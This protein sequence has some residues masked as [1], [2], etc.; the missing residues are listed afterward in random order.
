MEFFSETRV[1]ERAGWDEYLT[2]PNQ[3][4]N[5]NRIVGA[6]MKIS[7]TSVLTIA[8]VMATLAGLALGQADDTVPP[9][10][11]PSKMLVLVHH[12]VKLGKAP[13]LHKLEITAAGAFDR[14]N[15]PI[16]WIEL[17]GLTG[18]GDSLFLD[19]FDSYDDLETGLA[20]LGQLYNVHPDLARTQ[21]SID[22]LLSS[23]RTLI[24]VRRDDLSPRGPEIDESKAR[25]VRV[26]VVQLRPGREDEF[27]EM[28]RGSA[29]AQVVYQVNEGASGPT[30]IILQPMASLKEADDVAAQEAARLAEDPTVRQHSQEIQREAFAGME[31]NLYVVRPEMSHVAREFAAGDP[32]FWK[33]QK[34]AGRPAEEKEKRA[35]AA[36]EKK[37]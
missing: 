28:A 35:P 4:A 15:A 36:A 20:V 31:S 24:A 2:K 33:G 29:A 25:Y 1:H 5:K 22:E 27:G 11:I 14:L 8:A 13:D 19:P 7:A 6:S 21:Q 17:E 10:G 12:E 9:G 26:Q 30:F 3:E 34:P 16:H 32:E 37:P 23:S 18:A